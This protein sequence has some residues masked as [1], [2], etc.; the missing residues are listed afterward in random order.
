MNKKTLKSKS[1]QKYL[2]ILII[3]LF[4]CESELGTVIE[5]PSDIQTTR[6]IQVSFM[7]ENNETLLSLNNKTLTFLFYKEGRLL[8]SVDSQIDDTKSATIDVPL[9]E[10]IQLIVISDG[11]IINSELL[12]TLEITTGDNYDLDVFTSPLTNIQ[13]NGTP[14]SLTMTRKVGKVGLRLVDSQSDLVNAP[15]D[16]AIIVFKNIITSYFP[17]R[18][19]AYLYK[20]INKTI[21]LSGNDEVSVHSFA[22][23][24]IEIEENLTKVGIEFYYKNNL[25]G[26]MTDNQPL[27]GIKIKPSVH[28]VLEISLIKS[29]NP[30]IRNTDNNSSIS[31]I[32]N[33]NF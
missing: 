25:V 26:K 18:E 10:T 20:V 16:N 21:T 7:D 1:K 9:D 32:N 19:K 5:T 13:T 3:S 29:F 28:S 8:Q 12:E 17:G 4:S 31:N 6:S 15:F 2:L 11:N 33:Y 24:I 27:A 14:I 30:K 22:H 23:P